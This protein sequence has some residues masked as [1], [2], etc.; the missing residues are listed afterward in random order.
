MTQA[1]QV[2]AGPRARQRLA[3]RGLRAADVQAVPAAAGGPKGLVLNKLDQFLFGDWLPQGGQ[4][5]HLLGASIGAWR[6]ATACMT[7]SG[8]EIRREF[9]RLAEEYAHQRY[10]EPSTPA[11]AKYRMPDAATVTRGFSAKLDEVFAGHE[12]AVL[13]HPQFRLHVFTSRG[14]HVLAREGRLRTPVGYLGAFGANAL[15]RR[16][17]GGWLERVVFSDPRAPLP[18]PLNDFRSRQVALTEQNLRPS[19]LASCSIPFWLQAVHDIP[20]APRGAY[21]DGGIT[22]Y[23]LH[24]N[25]AAMGEGALVLYPHFQRQVVPGWLDKAFKG[26]HRASRFLDNLVVLA[27][28]PEWVAKLPRSKLPDRDD[29]KHYGQDVD[30]RAKAW[31]RAVREGERLR[32]EF[33]ALC[34]QDSVQAAAL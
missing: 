30:A 5:V 26:R 31:L 15:A 17:L 7:R 23:H 14:R 21:W 6:M 28:H 33:V 19:V 16:L 4:P 32:D 1:L 9:D 13:S 12:A 34:Q 2:F 10:D 24:L 20:G 11:G 18:L 29:F 3:E 22:D 25:Y 8:A 27:P